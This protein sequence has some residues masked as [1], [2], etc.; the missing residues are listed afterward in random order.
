MFDQY[1][2]YELYQ[3]SSLF[4]TYAGYNHSEMYVSVALGKS[5]SLDVNVFFRLD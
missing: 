4:A 3:V 2:H 1:L 5:E